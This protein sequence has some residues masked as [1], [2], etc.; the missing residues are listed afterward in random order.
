MIT[1]EQKAKWLE[2]LRGGEYEQCLH[3]LQEG[4]GYC[5]LG[6]AAVVFGPGLAGG[7]VWGG[8]WGGSEGE[9]YGDIPLSSGERTPLQV[10]QYATMRE[11]LWMNDAGK[12]F[13]EIADYLEANLEVP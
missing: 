12:S 7:L 11:A 3:A 8:E 1:A 2:A 9:F 10:R 6:V 4:D 5:C 13:A